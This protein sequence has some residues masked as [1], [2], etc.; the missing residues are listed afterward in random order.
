MNARQQGALKVVK[1]D[2]ADKEAGD[3]KDITEDLLRAWPLPGP[4]AH[5]D[6]E[7][8][9]AVLVIGG[10]AEVPGA[11]ILAGAAALR[12]G[13]G[14]LMMATAAE[15]APGV[16]LAMPEARVVG[17]PVSGK[18][19]VLAESA[20]R[21]AELAQRADAVLVG[22]G[23][24]DEGTTCA[25]VAALLPLLRADLPVVLDAMAMNVA[26]ATGR[27]TQPVILTPHAGEMAHLCGEPKDAVQAGCA[28]LAL[29]A[30]QRFGAVVM[31]KGA[32]THL[33]VPDGR[34]WRH[35]GHDPG[36]GTSGSGDVLAG[37]VAGLAARGA[38]L[39]QAGVWAVALHAMA[40]ARLGRQFSP[41]GYLARELAGEVPACLRELGGAQV[42]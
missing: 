8:R 35:E 38:P 30:A 15:V 4:L 29:A 24:L 10:S 18:G 3:V 16:A 28:E 1:G 12:A 19:G 21:A 33:A 36:L 34:Q 5:G 13:A 6:K 42:Q 39:E 9:G 26:S 11:L 32:V 17:L 20:A 37:I 25:F 40:G 14:K 31:L 2:V 23:M 41:L 27:F 22:P 7:S